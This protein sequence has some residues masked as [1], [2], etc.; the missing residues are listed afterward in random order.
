[1]TDTEI[2]K[3]IAKACGLPIQDVPFTPALASRESYYTPAAFNEYRKAYP[4]GMIPMK[5]PDYCNDLNAMHE[6]EKQLDDEEKQ[7]YAMNLLLLCHKWS[8]DLTKQFYASHASAR[9][10]AEAFLKVKGLWK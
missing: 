2:N 5:V 1:M 6:A 8:S 7:L 4:S 9:Q 10:R 3:A